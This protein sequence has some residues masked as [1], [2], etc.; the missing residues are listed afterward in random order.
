M[1]RIDLKKSLGKKEFKKLRKRGHPD[2]M[3]PMLAKLHHDQFSDAGW[4]YERKLD[5]ERCLL[6]RHKN[7]VR[8][9]TRNRKEIGAIYPELQAAAAAGD[10][11]DFAADGEIVAFAGKVTSFARLQK[12]MHLQNKEEAEK[13]GV[14]VYFY[15]FDL[16]Y[17]DGYDLS[18]LPLRQRKKLLRRLLHWND[19]LRF[20][21]HR[22]E[23]GEKYYDEACT[24]GWEGIIAKEADSN[25]VHSRSSKWLKFKCSRRQ[26]FVIGGYT[27][28]QGSR[29]GF[30]ALLLG[31]YDDDKLRYAGNVGTGFDDDFLQDFG[32]RLKKIRRQKSPFG[33]P[34]PGSEKP[35]WVTPRYVGEIGF[36]EW[37]GKGRLRHPRFIG[38]R[39]DKKAEN[40]VREG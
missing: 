2:W 1:A 11:D 25:Y 35:N 3:E 17:L 38:L 20:T 34:V 29:A 40:V 26:E 5:G 12:R 27:D 31:Y 15:L 18:Q 36:T 24:K 33:D 9:L 4:I 6:F 32:R 16:M 21:P 8:L 28:P 39:D 23:Q 10:A 19:P 7:R 22:N 14:A 30:G 37:T 13:S